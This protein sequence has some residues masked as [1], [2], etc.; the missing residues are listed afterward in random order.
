MRMNEVIVTYRGAGE[1]KTD[2]YRNVRVVEEGKYTIVYRTN[3]FEHRYPTAN[4][5]KIEFRSHD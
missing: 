5:I 4:V 2:T 1:E 3:T